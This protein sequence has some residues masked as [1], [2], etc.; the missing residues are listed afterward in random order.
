MT[1]VIEINSKKSLSWLRG[2]AICLQCKH[3]FE[4]YVPEGSVFFECPECST[5]KAVFKYMCSNSKL[6]TCECGC[7]VFRVTPDWEIMCCVCGII[8]TY[9]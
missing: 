1:N 7:Q 8:H 4:A 3:E 6:V 9:E 5:E 2:P